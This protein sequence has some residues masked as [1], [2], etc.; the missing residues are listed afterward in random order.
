MERPVAHA[1]PRARL[2]QPAYAG[3]PR[4][5]AAV[6]HPASRR[7]PSCEYRCSSRPSR[8]VVGAGPPTREV[9]MLLATPPPTVHADARLLCHLRGAGGRHAAEALS[10]RGQG[11]QCGAQSRAGAQCGAFFSPQQINRADTA[12]KT[13]LVL[14]VTWSHVTREKKIVCRKWARLRSFLWT[15]C[16]LAYR[17]ST[18]GE[19]QKAPSRAQLA[20]VRSLRR[21]SSAYAGHLRARQPARPPAWPPGAGKVG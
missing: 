6:T 2:T 17:A 18:C 11:A 12:A 20:R 4:H 5:A 3:T 1:G 9:G 10:S 15:V 19:T 13:G 16:G 7:S 14:P 8:A 21:T